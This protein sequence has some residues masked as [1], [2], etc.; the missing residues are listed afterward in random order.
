MLAGLYQGVG[1]LPMGGETEAFALLF[2]T[3]PDADK[4][5]QAAQSLPAEYA[6]GIRSAR[7]HRPLYEA[8]ISTSASYTRISSSICVSGAS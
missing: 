7:S 4:S 5:Q 2:E 8:G 3:D 1:T 6:S